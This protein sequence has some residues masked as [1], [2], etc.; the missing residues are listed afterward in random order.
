MCD[1]ANSPKVQSSGAAQ[2]SPEEIL[3]GCLVGWNKNITNEQ[4]DKSKKLTKIRL[5]S[6][7]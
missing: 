6:G 2:K 1:Q 4:N 7:S 3:S 5:R